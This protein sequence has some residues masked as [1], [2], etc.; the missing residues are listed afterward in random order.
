MEEWKKI[1]VASCEALVNSMSKRVRA[2]GWP[3]SIIRCI[4]IL[5]YCLAFS[6]KDVLTFFASSVF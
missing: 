3:G 5:G 4:N 2:V 6:L 1:L